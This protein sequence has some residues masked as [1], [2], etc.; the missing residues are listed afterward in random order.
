MGAFPTAGQTAVDK[1][2]Y[3][4][5]VGQARMVQ[6]RTEAAFI[7]EVDPVGGS[8]CYSSSKCEESGGGELHV[9]D[10]ASRNRRMRVGEVVEKYYASQGDF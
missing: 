9:N 6:G 5:C 2:E 10:E 1:Q 3:Q 8:A 7:D 4:H